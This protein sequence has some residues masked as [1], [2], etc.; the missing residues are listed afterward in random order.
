MLQNSPAFSGFSVHDLAAAKE[1][2]G[3]TLG[4]DV[5]QD[6]MGLHL[7][8][9]FGTHIFIYEKPDHQPASFTILNFPVDDINAAIDA[10]VEKGVTFERYDNLPA[11]QDERG[12]LR[13]KAAGQ[14][15]DIAWF[16]DPSGNVLSI[17]E[18]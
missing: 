2:Y 4:L 9:A 15:P 8:L 18:S 17:L 11:P 10:L 12:V 1:F 16:R 13:G 5:H 7:Q 14:G 3:D 6:D